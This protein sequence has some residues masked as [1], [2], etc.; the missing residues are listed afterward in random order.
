MD[1]AA[2]EA[3]VRARGLR[4]GL[5]VFPGEPAA[6]TADFTVPLAALQNVYGTHHIGASTDQAQEAIAAEAVRIITTYMTTGQ[7]P[8]VVNLARTTPATHR[9]VVRH[10]D[11]PGVLANVFDQLRRGA[12]NVQETENI[13]FEGAEA[14]VARINLDRE[15]DG[16][17]IDE[18]RRDENVIDIRL[19]ALD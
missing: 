18:L 17:T 10:R 16:A 8:N 11:R 6:G 4:V 19:V 1:Y 12:V 5:D 9:L 2:L 3:G 13:I 14:A 7:V 15:P